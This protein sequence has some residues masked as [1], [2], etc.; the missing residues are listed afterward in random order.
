MTLSGFVAAH[1][2]HPPCM[3]SRIL[4]TS[5]YAKTHNEFDGCARNDEAGCPS[6]RGI[7]EFCHTRVQD[8]FSEVSESIALRVR[9][10]GRRRGFGKPERTVTKRLTISGPESG[11]IQNT[12][13]P[14][15]A[16][17]PCKAG[18]IALLFLLAAVLSATAPSQSVPSEAPATPQTESPVTAQA[19]APPTPQTKPPAPAQTETPVTAQAETP[20][21]AQTVA[22]PKVQTGAPVTAQ[23]ETPVAA[24]SETPAPAQAKP[25]APKPSRTR[26]ARAR[27]QPPPSPPEEEKPAE[28]LLEPPATLLETPVSALPPPPL[29][30]A[31]Q[32][33]P[34]PEE[35]PVPGTP[36]R[37]ASEVI[38]I[39][40]GLVALF[41]LATLGA[42]PN[43]RRIERRLRLSGV[44][45]A[46]L[47]FVILGYIA[48]LPSV[49][50]LPDTVLWVLRPVLV[51]ALGWIGFVVGFRFD[52]A[53][54]ESIERRVAKA[55]F[56]VGFITFTSILFFCGLLL[57]VAEP[58]AEGGTFFRDAILIASAGSVIAHRGPHMPVRREAGRADPIWGLVHIQ[59][60][61]GIIGLLIVAA[62]FR[63]D[64]AG[65]MWQLPGTAWLFIALGLGTAIGGILYATLSSVKPGPDFVVVLLGSVGFAAGIAGFLRL[66][67][68]VVCFFAGFI[69]ANL[70]FPTKAMVRSTLVRLERPIYLI[71]LVVSGSLLRVNEWQ[72]WMIML[73][74]VAGTIVGRSLAWVVCRRRD[75][76]VPAAEERRRLTLAP[77]G[78]LSVAVA[79]NAQL[80]YYGPVISWLVVGVIGASIITEVLV[81]FSARGFLGGRSTAGDVTRQEAEG[82]AP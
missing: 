32:A 27:S 81:Q 75:A 25:A 61:A 13:L 36:F 38:K 42:H 30:L 73:L 12:A 19:E 5:W 50:V 28:E 63:P 59:H 54:I 29:I 43:V 44:I 9:R 62:Y 72:G 49:G 7:I 34:P 1:L 60:L 66:S 46:G 17:R 6:R 82:A 52:A 51:L 79:V 55:G 2:P 80:L 31:P 16:R 53:A 48:S 37:T 24:P 76:F 33:P 77:L 69:L 11:L 57:I 64:D 47:P 40:L 21:T 15:V 14:R 74:L 18:G 71:F 22:P 4:S 26:R 70:P 23:T 35:K 56:F 10:F 41:A 58:L 20:A 65:M 39:I 45:T 78:A 8:D 68:I 67:P 3:Q